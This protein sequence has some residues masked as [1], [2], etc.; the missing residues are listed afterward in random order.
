MANL[1]IVPDQ[2]ADS[3]RRRQRP[4]QIL[5]VREKITLKYTDQKY[6][7]T[8]PPSHRPC[9]EQARHTRIDA[10]GPWEAA[11]SDDRHHPAS[12]HLVVLLLL[13]V[14]R[15]DDGPTYWGSVAEK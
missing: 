8:H 4:G 11:E 12:C 10:G 5:P 14:V 15:G 2:A 7:R 1:C 13:C 6:C 9:G 3:G